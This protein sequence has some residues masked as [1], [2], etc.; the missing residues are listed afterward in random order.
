MGHVTFPLAT[1]KLVSIRYLV[2]L[3]RRGM[4]VIS[5]DDRLHEMG[6]QAGWV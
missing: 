4:E 3:G 2:W 6:D 1:S 5:P